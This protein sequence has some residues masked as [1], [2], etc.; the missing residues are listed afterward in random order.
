M[1]RK[2]INIKPK[3]EKNNRKHQ[4]GKQNELNKKNN[5]FKIHGDY[6]LYR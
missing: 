5:I 3:K 4:L 2:K 6:L 1:D